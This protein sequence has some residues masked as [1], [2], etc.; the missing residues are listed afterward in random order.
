M[1]GKPIDQNDSDAPVII[2]QLSPLSDFVRNML[3][4]IKYTKNENQI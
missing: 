1:T 2:Q 3:H 4:P